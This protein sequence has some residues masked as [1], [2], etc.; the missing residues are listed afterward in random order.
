MT[1]TPTESR[2]TGE[3]DPLT[4]RLQ[5]LR[6]QAGEPSY[7]EIARR[8]A[9]LRSEA[10]RSEH[11]ARVARTTVYDAFRTGRARVNLELVREI[12]AVLG[13]D[14]HD[15]DT[16]VAE[17][18]RRPEPPV[19]PTPHETTA[20]ESPTESPAAVWSPPSLRLVLVLM[21]LC[22]VANL[23]GR[24]LV[25][26]LKL[27]IH[28]DM[29]GTATAAIALGPWFGAGVGL[30]SNLAGAAVSGPDS[31]P[32]ALVNMAGALAWGYGVRRFAMGRSL[33]RFLGLNVVVAFVC[34]ALAVPL[35]LWYLGSVNHTQNFLTVTFFELTGVREAAIALANLVVSLGDKIISGFL[36][37][38]ACSMLPL[39]LRRRTPLVLVSPDLGGPGD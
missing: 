37:L 6:V 25:V 24:F 20:P 1:D 12:A 7:G 33:P 31:I 35:I 18:R 8:V 15:V 38:V 21:A 27:P 34:S 10:G 4:T 29:V 2:D 30:T 13:G 28:L 11:E 32:F 23:V 36:A 39:V 9:R 16:W 26:Q 22:V 14:D 5:Q 3:W 19:T 17:C